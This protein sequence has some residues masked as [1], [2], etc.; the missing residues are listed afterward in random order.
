MYVVPANGFRGWPHTPVKGGGG[1]VV[2]GRKGAK[3]REG[4]EGRGERVECGQFLEDSR[5]TCATWW[6]FTLQWIWRTTRT[7]TRRARPRQYQ[8]LPP[9]T[10]LQL[11]HLR[12]TRLLRRV[13]LCYLWLLQK[14]SLTSQTTV[15]SGRSNSAEKVGHHQPDR[16]A[17]PPWVAETA[18]PG[19][20]RPIT[21]RRTGKNKQKKKKETKIQLF[22]CSQGRRGAH[23]C[24]E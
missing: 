2:R 3:N 23:K 1:W 21:V 18:D 8:T 14:F 7:R 13:C 6:W 15:H 22:A 17:G 16:A 4:E 12:P 24:Q 11:A 20:G 10:R 5:L 19:P 9:S